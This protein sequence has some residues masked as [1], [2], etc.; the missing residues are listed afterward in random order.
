MNKYNNGVE[1]EGLLA[2]EV[3]V[4]TGGAQGIGLAVVRTALREGAQVAA[5]DINE[6][7][8][9]RAS[10]LISDDR[11]LACT[12]DLRKE[13]SIE[14]GFRRVTRAFG[15]TTI[16]IN[17]AGDNSNNSI[18]EMTSE[19][20]DA[21]FDL[22]LKASW[23]CAKNA[24]PAMIDRAYGSIVNVA[25]VHAHMTA[26]GSFPYAAAKS[27]LIGLTRSMAL[28]L[29]PKGVR[30]NSVSPGYTWTE[31]LSSHVA[32]SGGDAYANDLDKK[33]ALRRMGEPQDIAEVIVFLASKRS[34]WVTG[35]DWIVDGGLSS[36]FA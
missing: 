17:N 35:A 11:F 27:G 23:L 8:L 21:F 34:A 28:D 32:D 24:T 20:W 7:S 15:E 1:T 33:H 26:E 30:V 6:A 18:T 29:G 16:L 3:V 12:V 13:G 9:R 36:R 22:D 4:V 14:T 10:N 25:S 5:F 2:G 19:E 31:R